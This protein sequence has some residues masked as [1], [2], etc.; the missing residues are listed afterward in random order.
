MT[1]SEI[2]AIA[3]DLIKEALLEWGMESEKDFV[4][5]TDGVCAVTNRV[6]EEMK[7]RCE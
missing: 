3:F 5:Y 4:Q 2:K 1:E 7:R 6:I